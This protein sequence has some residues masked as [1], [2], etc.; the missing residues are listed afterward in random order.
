SPSLFPFQ[1]LYKAKAAKDAAAMTALVDGAL[2]SV[3]RPRGSVP[4]EEVETFCKNARKLLAVTT[5]SI[6]EEYGHETCAK[7]E[8]R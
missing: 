7:D 6:E 8:V 4:K 3:G 2:D 1:G 5:R